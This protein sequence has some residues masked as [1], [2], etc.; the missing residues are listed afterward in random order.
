MLLLLDFQLGNLAFLPLIQIVAVPANGRKIA[1]YFFLC[2]SAVGYYCPAGSTSAT[3][4]PCPA[5]TFGNAT[6]LSSA[7]CSGQCLAGYEKHNF[8]PEK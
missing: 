8:M 1:I 6:G 5:G 2:V 7:S 4:Q 3:S